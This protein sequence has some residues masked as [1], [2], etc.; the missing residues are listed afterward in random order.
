MRGTN[1]AHLPEHRPIL[2]PRRE[3]RRQ[4]HDH[5]PTP[6]PPGR[7]AV[8][9]GLGPGLSQYDL[10]QTGGSETVT[11]TASQVPNHSHGVAAA[12]TNASLED[13]TAGVYAKFKG[14]KGAELYGP[15]AGAF[16]AADTIGMSGGNQPHE[17]RAPGLALTADHRDLRHLPSAPLTKWRGPG[18]PRHS[19]EVLSRL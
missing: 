5:L 13:P 4:R 9:Q 15:N 7:V 14:A 16:A 6:R 3:L 11:L 8:G 18:R 12:T 10:G 19:F 2:A 1:P 17:N